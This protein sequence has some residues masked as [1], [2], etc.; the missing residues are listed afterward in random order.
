MLSMA[1]LWDWELGD[2]ALVGCVRLVMGLR[3]LH[4]LFLGI[5]RRNVVYLLG[6]YLASLIYYESLILGWR[7]QQQSFALALV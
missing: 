4:R 2:V 7:V 1:G 3:G 5:D 6:S